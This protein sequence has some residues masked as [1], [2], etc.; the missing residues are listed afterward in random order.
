MTIGDFFTKMASKCGISSTDANLIS[1]LSSSELA[2]KNMPD[3]LAN[4]L[5][6]GLMTV[7]AASA[8]PK[9]IAE[10]K[11]KTLNGVDSEIERIISELAIDDAVASTIK[12][13][14][15]SFKRI[16]LLTNAIKEIEGKKSSGKGADKEAY[17]QQ[18]RD[19][20]AQIMQIK[21]GTAKEID[22][23]KTQHQNSI[24]EILV[25]SLLSSKQYSLPDEL[26]SELKT[27]IAYQ[28]LTKELSAK[29]VKISSVNGKQVLQKLDG[30]PYFDESHVEVALPDFVDKVL[31][32]NKLLKVS[33]P[34]A[35]PSGVH[36][37]ITD[38]DP[39]N[40]QVV[41]QKATATI[42]GQL[43]DVVFPTTP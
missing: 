23:L 15:S 29:G 28:A 11:A 1:L 31:S 13:E 25:K 42:E 40:I 3:D 26:D 2:T 20:N 37:V 10:I 8:N 22:N 41:N 5:D 33:D 7:E 36:N 39:K 35:A 4:K 24:D 27:S 34:A 12:A 21:A 32:T 9:V 17:E 18:I 30:T 6:Q 43:K 16:G 19:L 14:Q 38:P